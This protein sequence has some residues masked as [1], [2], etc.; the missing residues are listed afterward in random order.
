MLKLSQAEYIEKVLKRFNM[1]DAN[2]VNIP[3]GGYFKLSKAQE[4]T[5]EDEKIL[6]SNVPY[7]SAV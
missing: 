5:S 6:M 1:E 3:L 7:A 4:P 2:P